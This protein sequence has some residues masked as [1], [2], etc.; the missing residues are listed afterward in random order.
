MKKAVDVVMGAEKTA[1]KSN[2]AVPFIFSYKYQSK[3]E[4]RLFGE[5]GAAGA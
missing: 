1:A 2:H 3:N 4:E 5:Q